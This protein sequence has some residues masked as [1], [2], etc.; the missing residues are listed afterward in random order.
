MAG[1]LLYL[2]H[3]ELVEAAHFANVAHAIRQ[4]I[5]HHIIH[6]RFTDIDQARIHHRIHF[7][8]DFTGGKFCTT[9]SPV[10]IVI[11]IKRTQVCIVRLCGEQGRIQVHRIQPKRSKRIQN[12]LAVSGKFQA[13]NASQ[14][15][16]I[17]ARLARSNH[18]QELYALRLKLVAELENCLNRV[19]ELCAAYIQR[20]RL[21]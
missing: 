14:A 12:R 5:R 17:D 19:I 8:R 13:I 20:R 10:R 1:Y 21:H 15:F 11:Q 16:W 2:E 6:R 18:H 7:F 9:R 3:V 4:R